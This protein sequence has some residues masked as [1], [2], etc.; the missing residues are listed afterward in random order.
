MVDC[1]VGGGVRQRESR[2]VGEVAVDFGQREPH[3]LRGM[4][5]VHQVGRR[6]ARR[7]RRRSIILHRDIIGCHLDGNGPN[8]NSQLIT[9][10]TG[11]V[12]VNWGCS[13]GNLTT[14]NLSRVAPDAEIS[15]VYLMYCRAY[16]ENFTASNNGRGES[17]SLVAGTSM[18]ASCTS[19]TSRRS[20][21]ATA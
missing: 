1:K 12:M 21:R 10:H 3:G 7:Q 11:G 2:L 16:P 5:H 13:Y 14:G 17:M 18:A 4:V 9:N 6:Y 19:A 15:P 8:P 20:A